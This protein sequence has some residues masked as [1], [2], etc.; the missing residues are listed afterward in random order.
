MSSLMVQKAPH[1]TLGSWHS[2][3]HSRHDIADKILAAA[4][5]ELT[6]NS[7][8]NSDSSDVHNPSPLARRTRYDVDY[9]SASESSERDASESGDDLVIVDV[10]IEED[11]IN[12]GY[13]GGQFTD[14]DLRMMARHINSTT[15]FDTKTSKL[16]WETFGNLVCSSMIL[17]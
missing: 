6:S 3:W 5:G 16:R 11:V 9:S 1:H 17:V 14:A 2:H 4:K 7:G 13:S 12:M 10:D 15:D 8:H